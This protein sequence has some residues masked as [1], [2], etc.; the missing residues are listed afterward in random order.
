MPFDATKLPAGPGK[1]VDFTQ[2]GL[3]GS[4]VTPDNSNDLAVYSRIRVWT[5]ADKSTATIA[6][7]PA[8]NADDA[9][10]TLN[11]A[12]GIAEVV[13][14]VVRR[15]LSTGTTSGLVIHAIV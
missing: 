15:V 6:F 2:L 11:L 10:I 12:P 8:M 7:L 9:P 13:P 1:E 14:Y 5:P 4:V 3:T